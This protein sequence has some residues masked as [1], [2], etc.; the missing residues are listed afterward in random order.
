MVL[1]LFKNIFFTQKNKS[2]IL[3]HKKNSEKKNV[4]FLC[5]KTY[6]YYHLDQSDH[7]LQTYNR[8]V[9][10]RSVEPHYVAIQDHSVVHSD[11]FLPPP[12]SQNAAYVNCSSRKHKNNVYFIW[13]KKHKFILFTLDYLYYEE[14][15]CFLA[16]KYLNLPVNG[17]K[18]CSRHLLVCDVVLILQEGL[19][20]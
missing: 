2:K 15:M 10:F 3:F 11:I 18:C 13:K 9:E 4:I 1:K 19:K 12:C 8:V 14:M 17:G 16:P 6:S 7:H 5:S 20:L